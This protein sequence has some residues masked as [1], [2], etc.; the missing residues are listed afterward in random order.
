MGH[1]T[2]DIAVPLLA[3]LGAALIGVSLLAATGHDPLAVGEAFGR[4]VL[5]RGAGIEESA[6]AMGP[7]LIAALAAWIAARVGLWNIGIDG[8]VIAGAIAAATLAPFLDT[9]P[10]ESMWVAVT[11]V[12]IVAGALWALLPALLRAHAGINEIVTT[13]MMTYVAFSLGSWLVEGPLR[14]EAL[15]TPVTVAI[16]VGRRLPRVFDT[17]IHLGVAAAVVIVLLTAAAARWTSPGILSRLVGESA[18]AAHRLGLPVERYVVVAFLV[19]GGVAALAGVAEVLATRGAVQGDWRPVLTLPAFAALFLARQNVL[20]L[21]PAAFLLGMLA[22]ASTVLP[23]AT[24]LAPDFFPM[25]EG[26]L[27]ILLAVERWQR[28]ERAQAPA[29]RSI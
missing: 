21:L 14:D 4:R 6:V 5:L 27:L 12:A 1:L 25:L 18:P 23:R 24:D 13:I 11:V 19:S 8:Q 9:W 2:R 26:V 15:V 7:L 22:Y 10:R 28:P 3:V 17:R 16:D 20:A 29:E